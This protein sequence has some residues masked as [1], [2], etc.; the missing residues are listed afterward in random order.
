[1]PQKKVAIIGA[2]PSGLAQLRAFQSAAAKGEAIPEIV[3]F[4]KQD[5]WGGLWNYTW[6]TGLDENGEPV[7]C[8]MYRYLWSNGPKEGL[9]FA[10][11]SFEEHFGKQIASYPPRAVLFDYIEGR[12]LKAGVRDMIRFNT[13]VRWISYDDTTGKF[14]V[15]VHDHS[16]DHVYSEEFDN[17]IVASGHFSVP[18]VPHYPGFESFNGRLLHAHDFRDAR[19]FTDKDILVMGSSYSAE[20]IGSQ[21]W[22]Y[23][24]K[25]VTSCY[26]SAP[27]GFDW[28]DN[29]EEKPA[30]ERVDGNTAYFKDGTSK[31]VDAII[32][33]TGYK[34][35]FNFLPDDLRLKT[36]NRLA[37]ADLYKGVVWVHNPKLFY[38]GMQ[39]Q[40]FTFNMFDA[41]AWWVRDAI[42]GKLDIPSDTATL[43]A[44]VAEREAREEA[45]DDTKYAIKYQGDYIKEL[46]AE[47]D[48]PSF[49]VDGACE[50]FYQWK[51]HKAQD[52]M[53]FR[54]NS[55][56]SV[57][58][59]TM[60]PVH[61]TPWKDALD[62]SMESYL[63]N[64]AETTPAE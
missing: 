62:D 6:R 52:I 39:D 19:E 42:M 8:S 48:Y 26:R 46:V 1:M 16:Q 11:Y 37:T 35:S 58:T 23:G 34:H 31:H 54:N 50:A 9:E 47:T 29:W 2:G 44:D 64:E 36:A 45:S 55:Y 20:D 43:L 60:A 18:N 17:V 14:T 5:N 22:K 49:D 53:A 25:S 57:I 4:E 3:C 41:Q 24:A 13:V 32:L 30:L 61:H 10:D 33:C 7:H 28:P 51:K 15:T 59:G 12:V 63:Q 38:L 40:W 21:C 56:R 27:M